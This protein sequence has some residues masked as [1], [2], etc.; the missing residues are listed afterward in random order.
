MEENINIKSIFFTSEE[1][2]FEGKI[3]LY[4]TNTDH[5]K[6]LMEKFKVIN[7]VHKVDR[8]MDVAA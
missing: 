5:L 6:N 4:V 7:G 1:G 2:F 8:I 3:M